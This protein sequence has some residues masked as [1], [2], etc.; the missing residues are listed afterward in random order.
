MRRKKKGCFG[1]LVFWIIILVLLPGAVRM[2]M[3]RLFPT[4]YL[5]TVNTLAAQNGLSPA[6]LYGVIKAESNFDPLAASPKGAKGLMQLMDKT[7]EE[8]AKKAGLPLT[9]SFDPAENMALGAYYL[10]SLLEKYNGNE[11][12]ALC[13]YNAGQG[14]VDLWLSD[15]QY[16]EDGKTLSKIPFPET[17]R[18]VKKISLYKKIYE[19]LLEKE[20]PFA[21]FTSPQGETSLFVKRTTS[22]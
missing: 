5:D 20:K 7:A 12:A 11:K 4:P 8:C 15:S 6:L 14:R 3:G 17:E 9:D 22:L 18:Y 2:G 16:S 19:R 1:R 21:F 13:A 10:G